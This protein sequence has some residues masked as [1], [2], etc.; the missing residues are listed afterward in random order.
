MNNTDKQLEAANETIKRARTLWTEQNETIKKL[1]AE[2]EELRG[3]LEKLADIA[4]IK[5]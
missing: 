5:D 1:K 3:Y 4:G 2:N